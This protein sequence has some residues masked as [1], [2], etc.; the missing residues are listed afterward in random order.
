[1]QTLRIAVIGAGSFGRHHVRHLCRHPLVGEV[2]VVDRDIARAASLAAAHGALVA[3]DLDDLEVDA[4]TVAVPT[5]AHRAVAERMIARRRHVF[6]EKPIAASDADAAAL[7]AAAELAGVTLQVGHIERFSPVFRA[8][9]ARV[10]GVRHIAIRRHNPPRPVP[11]AADVVHDLMIH[12]I[13]LAMTLAGAPVRRAEGFAPG[14][15][16]EAATASLRFANGVVAELSASR[17]SREV[18]RVITVRDA[19]GT[20]RAD[21]SAGTL[22]RTAG[23]VALPVPVPAAQD[24]L[25][26]ELDEFVRSALGLARPAV[27]GRAGAAALAVANRVRASLAAPAL[28]LTA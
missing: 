26:A 21:L 28:Q 23:G 18:E 5:E 13:D 2:T 9:A 7:I 22:E 24:N 14:G 19:G 8:L 6:V 27:D 3:P 17:L 15:S 20:W 16:A 10:E 4:A 25:A 1:M 11:P 12:D